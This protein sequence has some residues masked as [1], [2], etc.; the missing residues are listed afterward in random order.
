MNNG[1]GQVNP[2]GECFCCL[3]C[4]R[5]TKSKYGYCTRCVPLRKKNGARH[6]DYENRVLFSRVL[7]AA[8]IRAETSE[9]WNSETYY[10]GSIN[11]DD[12]ESES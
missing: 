6:K 10:M 4:G 11:P 2:K 1:A 5:E 9:D 12:A 3:F 8:D 7:T